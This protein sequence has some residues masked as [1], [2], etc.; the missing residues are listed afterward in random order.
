MVG[1]TVAPPANTAAVRI[2]LSHPRWR[3]SLLAFLQESVDVVADFASDDALEV[4]ILGSRT[5]AAN[6]DELEDRL[7]SWRSAHPEA[8]AWVEQPATLAQLAA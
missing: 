3:A 2:T 1:G 4:S 7:E 5:E 6:H 8:A